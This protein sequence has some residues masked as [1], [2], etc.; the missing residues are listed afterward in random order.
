MLQGVGFAQSSGW[1]GAYA[2][3][4]GGYGSGQSSQNDTAIPPASK[5]GDG[6]YAM[7]GGM[8]GG[9]AGYNLQFGTWVA[10]IEADYAWSAMRGS[11]SACG[12]SRCG[13]DLKSFGTLRA[14]AGWITSETLLFATFGAAVGDISAYDTVET[15]GRG[16]KIKAGWAAGGGIERPINAQWSLKLEYLY[17]DFGTSEYFTLSNRTPEEVRLH[18][19]VVRAGLNFR[20]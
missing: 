18:T 7:K 2:G 8:L 11:S 13:T 6:S 12:N 10:G 20:F 17:L 9:T 1:S 3:A 4:S 19:S 16:R 14:R 5:E 15:T